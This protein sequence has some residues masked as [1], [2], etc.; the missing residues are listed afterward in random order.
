MTASAQLELD[1]LHVETRE[2]RIALF[3]VVACRQ[4]APDACRLDVVDFF[5]GA[6]A[7]ATEHFGRG[8]RHERREE[9]GQEF[10]GALSST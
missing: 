7:Q 3:H 5:D 8:I 2:Q 4:L 6:K 10:H 1:I 9:Q